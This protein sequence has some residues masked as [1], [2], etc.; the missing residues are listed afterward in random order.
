L[1]SLGGEWRISG[2]IGRP[3][4]FV[5]EFYQ[6]VDKQ[7]RFFIAPSLYANQTLLWVYSGDTTVAEF[8]S[9]RFGGALN[10]GLRSVHRPSGEQASFAA[11]STSPTKLAFRTCRNPTTSR[12]RIHHALQLRYAG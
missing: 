9:R 10:A 5:T 1:N 11:A 4:L 12:W 3:N 6:P 8:D 7:Q 2:Q